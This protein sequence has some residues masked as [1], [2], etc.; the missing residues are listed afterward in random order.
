MGYEEL[1]KKGY[2]FFVDVILIK[3]AKV[4]REIVSEVRCCVL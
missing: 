4:F 2:D 3:V 1:K